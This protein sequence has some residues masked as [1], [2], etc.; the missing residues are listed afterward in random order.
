M[1]SGLSGPLDHQPAGRRAG[2]AAHFEA[3]AARWITARLP[4]DLRGIGS[5]AMTG[6]AARDRIFGVLLLVPG[7][8]IGGDIAGAAHLVER[9]DTGELTG[10]KFA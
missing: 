2:R 3:G 7:E 4:T 9:L 6:S 10:W 1:G 5:I 8:A